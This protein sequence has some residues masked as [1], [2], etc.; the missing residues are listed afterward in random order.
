MPKCSFS[1]E[2][3]PVGTGIMY[4]QADGKV[5]HFKNS[6]SMKNFL[7]L[8]RKPLRT[9]WTAAYRAEKAKRV[10]S[11]PAEAKATKAAPKAAKKEAPKAE[12]KVAKKEAPKAE[13]K[14]AKKEA[15][16][17]KAAPKAAKKEAPK[18]ETKE[19]QE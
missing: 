19:A 11:M 6:K 1:G 18:A 9:K 13:A 8:K 10:A 4:V 5:F 14:V 17:A 3:I 12:T 2:S 16:K 15:P 7:K